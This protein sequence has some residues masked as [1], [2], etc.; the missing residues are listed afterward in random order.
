LTAEARARLESEV[1][2][3]RSKTAQGAAWRNLEKGDVLS[4]LLNR[5]TGFGIG[6]LQISLQSLGVAMVEAGACFM[7]G[8][9]LAHGQ[10]GWAAWQA[11]RQ[12]RR[13]ARAAAKARDVTPASVL[14]A[15]ANADAPTPMPAASISRPVAEPSPVVAKR[16]VASASRPEPRLRSTSLVPAATGVSNDNVVGVVAPD[17]PGAGSGEGRE[18]SVMAFAAER[19]EPDAGG[20]EAEDD[21]RREYVKLVSRPQPRSA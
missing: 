17:E 18:L 2:T 3:L 6:D 8:L 20:V 10:A 15:V 9:S 1:A 4:V 14:M 7:L 21:L 13:E 11:K 12:A 5:L 16:D 19:L